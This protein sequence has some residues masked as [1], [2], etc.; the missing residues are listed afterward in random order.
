M[1]NKLFI[2]LFYAPQAK[3]RQEI[4]EAQEKLKADLISQHQEAIAQLKFQW[5]QDKE[6]EIQLQ[7]TKQLASA[8]KRWQEGQQ[9]VS[10]KF[11]KY[12]KFGEIANSF[13]AHC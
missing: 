12:N 8:K 3:R 4:E 6:T 13:L 2:Y 7:V 1:D 10:G 5:T 9:E 11:T